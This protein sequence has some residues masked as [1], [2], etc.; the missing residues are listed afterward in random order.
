[1]EK[2]KT[3]AAAKIAKNDEFRTNYDNIAAE[4]KWYAKHFQNKTVYC[5]CDDA[6]SQFWTYF[7][8]NFASLGLKKLIATHY[9]PSGNSSYVMAYEGGS[10]LDLPAG[11]RIE[12][13][14]NGDFRND[15]CVALLQ[16]ADVVVTNPPF[17]LF[18]PFLKQLVEHDKKF[19]ILGNINA[20]TYKET[21]SLIQA[22]KVWTGKA[23]DK[24]MYFA[25]PESYCSKTM[26]QDKIGRK[27][28]KMG[29]ITWYTNLDL[30]KRH[31]SFFSQE[32]AH[33]YYEDNASAYPRYCNYD[34]VE[35]SYVADIPIDYPGVMGVPIT[36]FDK[37][38]PTEFEIV[39]LG[40]GNLGKSVGVGN[41]DRSHKI[42]GSRDGTVYYRK[43][44][45]TIVPYARVLIRNLHP[46]NKAP[47]L[48]KANK[49]L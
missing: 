49:T 23:F 39:G 35:V 40:I 47:Q 32:S 4:M 5:N 45:K 30:A 38:N 34:A 2:H 16:E 21:F 6:D 48:T 41:Y 33:S 25:V 15:E 8:S 3:L 7:H 26:V 44:D 17:S 24:T 27:V 14:G 13:R 20:L 37:Y 43:N 11:K 18:R 1:M 46:V 29:G 12:L 31:E 42:P 28:A 22:N 36:F 9:E 19:V 10:D